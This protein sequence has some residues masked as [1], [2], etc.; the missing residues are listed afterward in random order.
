MESAESK[1]RTKPP[2]W[3]ARLRVRLVLLWNGW[4]YD[5]RAKVWEKSVARSKADIFKAFDLLNHTNADAWLGN[6][7]RSVQ[8]IGLAG[9]V[10]DH[11]AELWRIR[12]R[13]RIDSLDEFA[14]TIVFPAVDFSEKLP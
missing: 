8:F 10:I 9:D 11:Q 6:N 4:R 5:R 1:N 7:P 2:A 13:I 3:I 14:S 12:Y